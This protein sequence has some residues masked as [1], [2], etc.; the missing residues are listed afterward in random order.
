MPSQ[1]LR[2]IV[3]GEVERQTEVLKLWMLRGTHLES[4]EPSSSP[5]VAAVEAS[6]HF[7]SRSFLRR[8]SCPPLC[9]SPAFL[10]SLK[11]LPSPFQFA[12]ALQWQVR[13]RAHVCLVGWL[14][15][16]K[17]RR[18]PS[19]DVCMLRSNSID[20]GTSLLSW[21]I[22]LCGAPKGCCAVHVVYHQCASNA[23]AGKKVRW[24]AV[25]GRVRTC[26]NNMRSLNASTDNVPKPRVLH[27]GD[28]ERDT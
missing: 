21:K 22:V 1:C 4:A 16:R 10:A 20:I 13:A 24:V 9:A 23:N 15:C 12:S 7:R 11:H 2:K 8:S 27:V 17:S 5:P 6:C 18:V 3:E 25:L 19:D 26:D 28:V 14:P